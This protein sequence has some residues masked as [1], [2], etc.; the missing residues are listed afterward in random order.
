ML[1][2]QNFSIYAGNTTEVTIDIDPDDDITLVG[3]NILW[4]V[5]EQTF[6]LPTAGVDPVIQK[7]NGVGGTIVV[8]DPDLQKLK[9]P[10]T[11]EDTVGLLRNY[12]H[13]ATVVDPDRG[14][15]TIASGIMTV[16]GTENR[17]T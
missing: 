6:G 17:P 2:P 9:I 4:N 10:L 7:N 16:L 5:Y 13:E 15:I 14:Q 11:P 12:Y 8:T 1:D 3:A